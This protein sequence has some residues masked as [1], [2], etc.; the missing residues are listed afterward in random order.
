MDNNFWHIS[1]VWEQ[2]IRKQ[3]VQTAPL[4]WRGMIQELQC[5]KHDNCFWLAGASSYLLSLDGI[6]WMVD[7]VLKIKEVW[8]ACSPHLYQDL[9]SLTFILYTHAHNDHYQPE[10]DTTLPSL[11]IV[12]VVPKCMCNTYREYGE[13][14][15]VMPGDSITIAGCQITVLPGIHKDP[16]GNGPEAV[17]YLVERNGRR[18]YF[19]GDVRNPDSTLIPDIGSVDCLFSH[20]FLG[21]SGAKKYPWPEWLEQ[22]C[23]CIAATPAKRIFL[24]HLY[25]MMSESE[26]LYTYMSAGAIMDG[27]AALCPLSDVVIPQLGR[28]YSL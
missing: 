13:T 14:I 25:E 19:S 2:Q 20:V 1:P 12:R 5:G 22:V 27:L 7:P 9:Q 18:L 11:P 3:Y 8:D 26:R 28:R 6:H 21:K 16:E 17:Q 15:Y 4:L 24:G 23:T 10:F